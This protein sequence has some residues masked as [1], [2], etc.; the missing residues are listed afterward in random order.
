MNHYHQRNNVAKEGC[1]DV[2]V[3]VRS[4]EPAVATPSCS[5]SLL[6]INFIAITP[7][8]LVPTCAVRLVAERIGIARTRTFP[9]VPFRLSNFEG[10]LGIILRQSCPNP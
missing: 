10:Q 1:I 6:S 8:S 7:F 3:V 4:C 9:G 2:V 5:L